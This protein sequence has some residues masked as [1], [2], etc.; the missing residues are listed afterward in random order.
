M[1][2][3]LLNFSAGP[4]ILPEPVLE[5]ARTALWN[6]NDSG[7]GILE[8]SHRGAQFTKVIEEA[9]ANC[10]KLAGI[11]DDYDVLFLQGGAST[12]FFMAPMNWLGEGK[13]ASFINTGTWSTKAIAEAK[14][15]GEAHV[16]ASSEDEGF[17]YIPSDSDVHWK[18]EAT[19]A[20]YTSNNTIAG[21]QFSA[22]PAAPAGMPLFCD[23]SSDIFS[24]PKEAARLRPSGSRHEAAIDGIDIEGNV[25]SIGVLP[26]E[27]KRDLRGLLQAELLDVLDGEDVGLRRRASCTPSRGTCQ[28]PIPT[29]TRLVAGTFGRF[30]AQYQGVVCMR[31]SR[32]FSWMSIWRSIWMMPMRFEVHSAMP[33]TQGNPIEW[34]P[35]SI[36]GT[37]P[38]EAI[39]ATPRVIWSKLF[40]R[41]PGMVK[42]SPASHS[43]ICSRRSTPSS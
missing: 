35:P 34:S 3:R 21:T 13:S 41:L 29:C 20:H 38:E 18:P 12:Q 36:S 26:G 25:D 2:E 23:A 14:L 28:P 33:R 15:F 22:T 31:S 6:L 37:A 8:H 30:V 11:S 9:E 43:V 1:T 42:T 24:K 4:A 32:S 16:A 39:C 5:T 7:V 19:Y 40:S 17:S 27:L 10:R